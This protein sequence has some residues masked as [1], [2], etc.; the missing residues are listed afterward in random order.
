[1]R[2]WWV[3]FIGMAACTGGDKAPDDMGD[4]GGDTDADD[5]VVGF[6]DFIDLADAP[7]ITGDASCFQPGADWASTT[8]LTQAPT[9][10]GEFPLT[11]LVEDFESGD[12]VDVP[13]T[14]Q[15]WYS[16]DA[17]GSSDVSATTDVSG[18]V[19]F[20]AVPTCQTM[21]YK[22]TTDPV[23]DET[24]TTFKAHQVYSPPAGGTISDATFL[25]VSSTTYQLI[26][27]I[28]GV[29]IDDDR[30]V[31]AGTA[32]DC[33]R[34][35]SLPTD[36]DSGKIEGAQVIV[37]DENGQIP[38]SLTVNYF[39]DDFPNRDQQHTSPDGLWV[40][41]NV[42]AGN[43]RVEMWA[44]VAGTPTLLGATHILSEA[45]SI[46]IAN[47]FTGYGDGVKYPSVCE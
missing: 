17:S 6:D 35:P 27:S 16:D 5:G 34:D 33:T 41:S 22:V 4:G 18:I 12:P 42:P 15:L 21:T 40:A 36:D 9:A 19:T 26:P 2:A 28:L 13:A 31:I 8:W 44:K 47:I 1:M 7:D 38:P 43:L 23:L 30:A 46:N 39:V 3:G 24:K 25:S 11:G 10:G 32:F 14:V 20:D 37:Y 45:G 29:S